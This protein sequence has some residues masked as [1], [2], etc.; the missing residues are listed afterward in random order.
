MNFGWCKWNM[1]QR[2][3]NLNQR[4]FSKLNH[5]FKLKIKFKPFSKTRTWDFVQKIKYKIDRFKIEAKF[6]KNKV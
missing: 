5:S 2:N 3:L 4:I 1:I 6:W